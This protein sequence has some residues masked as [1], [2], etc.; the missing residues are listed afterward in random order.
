[1]KHRIRRTFKK[2]KRFV[3]RNRAA[4]ALIGTAIATTAGIL[5]CRE[6]E[7]DKECRIID[8]II[9]N[10]IQQGNHARNQILGGRTLM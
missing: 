4:L 6:P 9:D 3:Y 1:M 7:P 8:H 5:L 10:Q 2:V